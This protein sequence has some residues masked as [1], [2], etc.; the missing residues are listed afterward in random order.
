MESIHYP[1]DPTLA[2]RD[3]FLMTDKRFIELEPVS[4]IVFFYLV[5][6]YLIDKEVLQ[7]KIK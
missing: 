7:Y 5:F 3:A 2:L 1:T 4:L 6:H